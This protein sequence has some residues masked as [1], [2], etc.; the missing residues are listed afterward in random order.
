[1]KYPTLDGSGLAV[2]QI[3]RVIVRERGTKASETVLKRIGSCA[4][5][6]GWFRLACVGV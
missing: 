4:D 1:M 6:I 2:A 3:V 5:S